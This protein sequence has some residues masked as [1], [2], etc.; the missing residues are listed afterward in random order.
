VSERERMKESL[1]K[2]GSMGVMFGND[3]EA[4]MDTN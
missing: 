3:L 1:A 4:C 2:R